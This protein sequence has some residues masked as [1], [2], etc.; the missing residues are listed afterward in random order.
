MLIKSTKEEYHHFQITFLK[1][2]KNKKNQK[3]QNQEKEKVNPFNL[4]EI[5]M[6]TVAMC[7]SVHAKMVRL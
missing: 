3:R 6:L 4:S 2:N 7:L 5:L 1:V